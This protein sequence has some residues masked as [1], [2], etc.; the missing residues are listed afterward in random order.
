M[1]GRCPRR[2]S[3]LLALVILAAS[4]P[5]AAERAPFSIGTAR[6]LPAG[7]VETGIFQP[8]R[9]GLRSKQIEAEVSIQPLLFFVM[10]NLG[11]KLGLGRVGPLL[12]ATEQGV[13][14]PTPLLRLLARE[15]TGG[16][17]PPDSKIPEIL[18]WESALLASLP[19]PR[20]HLLTLTLAHTLG[21]HFGESDWPT[22]D[23]PLVYTRTAAYHRW[24]S[25]RYGIDLDG[26][27]AGGFYY[28]L[29]LDLHLLPFARGSFALEHSAMLSW[30]RA[31]G[32]FAIHLG[33]KLVVGEYPFGWQTHLLPL[34]DLSWAWN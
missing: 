28:F 3:A 27:I 1:S 20:K 6:V 5:A 8:M 23:L 30:R 19:L 10:P 14:Y 4:I 17:L 21:L 13:R 25:A 12:V 29:D 16:V 15:G 24:L 34:V 33:Y 18:A 11:A 7:R 31:T 26:R 32:G 9:W 2:A 22:I